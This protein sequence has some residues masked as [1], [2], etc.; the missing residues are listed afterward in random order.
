MGLI[1]GDYSPD[2]P[3]LRD[4]QITVERFGTREPGGPLL[5]EHG[6][7]SAALLVGQG[8][9]HLRGVV[10]SARL[11]IACTASASGDA[12]PNA[13]SDAVEW[14]APRVALIVIPLGRNDEHPRL[15][16]TVRN[17]AVAGCVLIAAA[18]NRADR[19]VLF[20][21][22]A[23]ACLAISA[24]TAMGS[25]AP[26]YPTSPDVDLIVRGDHVTAPVA[27]GSVRC[28]S[29]TSIACV[30]AGGLIAAKISNSLPDKMIPSQSSLAPPHPA[31]WI[32]AR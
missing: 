5:C 1:E 16:A 32:R 13:V 24:C 10:P 12:H 14:L 23:D 4:A 15:A 11:L 31:G 6:S 20:P 9:D 19:S 8:T 18:G 3:D 2:V 7:F 29:G 22:R 30:L 21:A 26:H 27:A 28:R 17:A 25:T